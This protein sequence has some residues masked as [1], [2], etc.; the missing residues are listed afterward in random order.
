MSSEVAVVTGA[1]SGIGAATARALASAG[2][3]VHAVARRA[4]RLDALSA[5]IGCVPHVIDVRDRDAMTDLLRPMAISL[6]VNNAGLGRAMASLATSTPDDI[7]RTIDTNVTA[8]LDAIRIVLPG[9]ME[10]QRGHIVNI[11]SM[12]G[13]YPLAAVLY[14]ASKGAVHVMCTNL[15]IELQGTGIRVTEICPGRVATDFYDVAIDD[16]QARARVKQSGIE[17]ITAH[18]VAEAVLYAVQAPHRVNV[19]RIEL[20]PTEQT[21]GGYQFVAGP[22]NSR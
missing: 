3:E 18:D 13:L 21:Y 6:L 14:G 16:E 5:E 7:D 11:G 19:N 22:E 12:A 20:Q 9:M 2:F 4:D 10:R 15:R 8:T 1:S 17:E